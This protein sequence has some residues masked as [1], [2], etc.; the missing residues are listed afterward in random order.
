M[1]SRAALTRPSWPCV[2]SPLASQQAPGLR[3]AFA[4][5]VP[6]F[7][8][9]GDML[10][11]EILPVSLGISLA[12]L[13]SIFLGFVL[14]RLQGPSRSEATPSTTTT[15]P[16]LAWSTAP[17]FTGSSP[18]WRGSKSSNARSIRLKTSFE[19]CHTCAS[20]ALYSP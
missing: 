10:F 7:A 9:A 15:R 3:L 20:L 13:D 6:A 8:D 1:G 19:R 11:F 17:S 18:P 14:L 16:T 5:P 4:V 12:A 2:A